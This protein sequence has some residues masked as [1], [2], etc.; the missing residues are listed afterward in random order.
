MQHLLHG[1]IKVFLYGYVIDD[2]Y[3]LN[4]EVKPWFPDH[5]IQNKTSTVVEET[6]TTIKQHK[7]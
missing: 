2:S 1:V 5:T 3:G 6:I 7:Q 4:A